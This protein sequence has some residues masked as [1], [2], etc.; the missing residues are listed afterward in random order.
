MTDDDDDDDNVIPFQ[1]PFDP[2]EVV[3]VVGGLVDKSGVVLAIYGDDLDPDE[4]S[5][6]LGVQ[7]S[8]AHRR[9]DRPGKGPPYSSTRRTRSSRDQT[10]ASQSSCQIL[11]PMPARTPLRT[12]SERVV[13]GLDV[14]VGFG[15][16]AGMVGIIGRWATVCK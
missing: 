11:L 16:F 14:V 13:E 9:G 12:G 7:P 3:A 2:A 15:A 6:K 1:R 4:V 5:A 8:S 10:G